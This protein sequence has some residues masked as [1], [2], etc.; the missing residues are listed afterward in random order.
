[1]S[2]NEY[3]VEKIRAILEEVF[4]SNPSWLDGFTPG[5]KVFLKL[6]LI[7]KREPQGAA[8]THPALVEAVVRFFQD[9]QMTVIIGDS[10]GGPYIVSLLKSV[11]KGCGIEEVARRTGAILN[12]DVTEKTMGFPSGKVAKS[13]PVISPVVD[14]DKVVSMPKLKTHMMMKY[15]GAVKNLFGV[16]PGMKKPDYHLKMPVV[17]DFADLLID[18]ALCVKP[19][20][21]IMDGIVGMEGHGPSRGEVRDVGALLISDDPFAMDVVAT[22]LVGIDPYSVPTIAG[23]LQ[24]GLVGDLSEIDVWGKQ[25]ADWHVRPFNTPKI[26]DKVNFPI[27]EFMSNLIRPRPVFLKEKCAA[28]GECV[29]YCPPKALSLKEGAPVVD[30]KVCIRC[31]CCQE[32]CPKGAVKVRRIIG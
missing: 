13:I 6:N 25:L 30:L 21:H 3:N 17:Q 31:F 4:A 22:S 15:T 20:L 12:Y 5:S 28:C 32:L 24:R 27:P 10:P 16:I 1:M 26:K 14:V 23:S 11:Y 18:I 29:R 8:T 2:C 19:S 7:L 9:R